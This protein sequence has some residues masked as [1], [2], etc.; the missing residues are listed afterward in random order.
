MRTLFDDF[1]SGAYEKPA[2]FVERLDQAEDYL[3][4]RL[5]ATG[6]FW[7]LDA[8]MR[9]M[10]GL[11]SLGRNNMGAPNAA[12]C[13]PRAEKNASGQRSALWRQK[14]DK[15][16]RARLRCCGTNETRRVVQWNERK[17]GPEQCPGLIVLS[18]GR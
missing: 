9:L 2:A 13:S 17:K 7:Q 11:P 10:L 18:K 8:K 5:A 14:T 15:L 12:S 16:T 3:N 1:W 4:E 6:E